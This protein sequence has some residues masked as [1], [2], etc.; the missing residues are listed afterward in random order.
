[1]AKLRRGFTGLRRN[2]LAGSRRLT[3]YP[4]ICRVYCTGFHSHS[5]S[6]TGPRPWPWCG[7]V[8]CSAPSYLSGLCSSLF[9]C[10]RRP[11][12]SSVHGN[13]VVPLACYAKMQTS[14]FSVVGP[15]TWN[16]LPI[17]LKHLPN[18]AFSQF[19]HLL[20]YVL[21]RLASK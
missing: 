20:N 1:M 17:D 16:G 15:T 13:L 3:T 5:A 12:Q 19:H 11:L 14:S 9:L 6:H 21:F 7:G 4:N 8:S 10:R 18:G 2:L